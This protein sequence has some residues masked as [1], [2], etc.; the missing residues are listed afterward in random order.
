[1]TKLKSNSRTSDG[2][3]EL[4]L[5][6]GFRLSFAE[7]RGVL[8]MANVEITD[9]VAVERL[10]LLIPGLSF[11]FDITRGVRGLRHRRHVL[12]RLKMT[13]TSDGL[14]RFIRN[15]LKRSAA[16]R[17][18]ACT[19]E[20]DH[21]AFL[22]R[23][24]P[25]GGRVPLSFRL[26]LAL[27]GES[28]GFTIGDIRTYGPLP[29][30]LLTGVATSVDEMLEISARG[31]EVPLPNL[32]RQA[33]LALLPPRGWRLPSLDAVRLK[34]LTLLPDRAVLDFCHPDRPE[35]SGASPF[36]T[37][38]SAM[39]RLLRQ[40]ENHIAGPADRLLTARKLSEARHAYIKLLDRDPENPFV[41]ARLAMMDVLTPHLR[42]A[43]R[44]LAEEASVR[45]LERRDL[46]AVLIHDAA[47][48]GDAPREESLLASLD[49]GSNA[50]EIL[51]A[52]LRRG[53]LVFDAS[54]EKAV[55]MYARALGARRDDPDALFALIRARA[56]CGDSAGVEQLI[57]R[58][59]AAHGETSERSQAHTR[60]G[61]ILLRSLD[62]PREAARHFER[63]TVADPDNLRAH[64]GLAESLKAMNE[65]ERAVRH[66]ERLA[67]I[68]QEAGEV[69]DAALALARLG[70]IWLD[71]GVRSLAVQRLIESL[72]LAPGHTERRL[73]LARVLKGMYRSAPAARE[74]ETALK[75]SGAEAREPWWGEAALELA[76]IY[77]DTL[78]DTDAAKTWA[79]AAMECPA[80]RER[81]RGLFKGLLGTTDSIETLMAG[82]SS[83]AEVLE[84]ARELRDAGYAEKARELLQ[85]G[86]SRFPDHLELADELISLCREAG[87]HD[88]LFRTL[89]ERIHTTVS[90]RRRAE[91]QAE[92][93]WL[94]LEA[95]DNPASAI[96]WFKS[97]LKKVQ[98]DKAEEGLSLA[99]KTLEMQAD[100]LIAAKEYE[101]ARMLFAVVET[102]VDTE[103][104]YADQLM[105]AKAAIEKGDF[106]YAYQTAMAA[107]RGSSEA[108]TQASLVASRA[109]SEQGRRREAVRSLEQM[110]KSVDEANAVA[111]ILAAID[112]SAK[113]IEDIERARFFLEQHL[114]KSPEREDLDQAIIRLLAITGQ[115][116]AL[117]EYLVRKRNAATYT[118]RLRRAAELFMADGDFNRAADC[119]E[120]LYNDTD[121]IEDLFLLANALRQAGHHETLIGLLEERKNEDQRIRDMLKQELAS[122]AA[123]LKERSVAK[124]KG[125][126][127]DRRTSA[128]GNLTS[129]LFPPDSLELIDS[130]NGLDDK[131]SSAFSRM[132]QKKDD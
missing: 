113:D 121:A 60:I 30:S 130:D 105:A 46:K 28:L 18:W 132:R 89:S 117:A 109:L 82:V 47:L 43:A 39:D 100:Q 101:A 12:G 6:D 42:E 59:I 26:S 34:E 116:S 80:V 24:G 83:P 127:R 93:G 88:C 120:A 17:L 104:R 87:D 35:W 14:E 11:P 40:E 23:F 55:E 15:R 131:L 5:S 78:G 123:L 112:I 99:Y 3:A 1:M 41:V 44:S 8:D 53:D 50:L 119:F 69:E 45:H 86:M 57:P 126:E 84:L 75:K 66:F 67:R 70:D 76:M 49:Q 110:S 111:L 106:E 9:A 22:V 77:L 58:W 129:S 19:F 7:G 51:A 48:D 10:Q 25:E 32:V 94:T 92:L 36:E 79:R 74:F 72:E 52:S 68:H 122:Y 108:R 61:E 102:D 115:R 90:P 21:L 73:H 125:G 95:Y 2:S 65:V 33:L 4:S 31:F 91:M 63:A 64:W 124:S 103:S 29:V 96:F 16:V 38:E 37:A 27:L 98:L 62:D 128:V 85:Q 97:A 71:R 56:A 81:A 54:P 118:A 107:S 20:K 114:L 13:V